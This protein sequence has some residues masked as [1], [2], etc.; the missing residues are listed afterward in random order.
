MSEVWF[1]SF[2]KTIIL[3]GTCEN[4]DCVKKPLIRGENNGN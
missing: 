2:G 1:V 4:T 3:Y